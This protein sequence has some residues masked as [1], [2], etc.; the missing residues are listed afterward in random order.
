[1]YKVGEKQLEIRREHKRT[2]RHSRESL[3]IT[4][5]RR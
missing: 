1:M 3:E 4:A 5:Q 2:K